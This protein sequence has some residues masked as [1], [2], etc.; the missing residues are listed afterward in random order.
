MTAQRAL[1]PPR[2]LPP[3]R[4]T[5]PGRGGPPPPPPPRA[6]RWLSSPSALQALKKD[7]GVPW[8]GMLAIVH[9]Y[10]THKT[11]KKDTLGSWE[12]APTPFCPT[13]PLDRWTHFGPG[14][15]CSGPKTPGTSP[16]C[17]AVTAGMEF[18]SPC[19]QREPPAPAGGCGQDDL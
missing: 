18:Q 3:A 5:Q 16:V 14:R 9:S 6:V 17:R 11:G 15:G 19:I 12:R 7:E 4:V 8:T 2:P 10:V 1:P 13:P